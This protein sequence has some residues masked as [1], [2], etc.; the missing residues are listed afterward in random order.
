MLT[1]A[2]VNKCKMYNKFVHTY[3]CIQDMLQWVE[4][5]LNHTAALLMKTTASVLHLLWPMKLDTSK[6]ITT[7]HHSQLIKYFIFSLGMEHDGTNSLCVNSERIM[8]P[9]SG[10][11]AESFL[12]SSCS[13]SYLRTF[14]RY[15]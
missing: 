9:S 11:K 15:V 1:T 14:L 12:W 3:V 4:C 10:G 13:V 5:V 7:L 6:N 2:V 8:A